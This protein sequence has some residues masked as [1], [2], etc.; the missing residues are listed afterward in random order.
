MDATNRIIE[1]YDRLVA[2]GRDGVALQSESDRIVFYVVS[3]RCEIDING[4]AS[5]FEQELNPR[6]LGMLID[7][8]NR[9]GEPGLAREFH[10]G[11]IL[12]KRDGFYEH[13]NWNKVSALTKDEIKAIGE[14]IGDRLWALDK[15]L[16][17]LLDDPGRVRSSSRDRL[18]FH[19]QHCGKIAHDRRPAVAAVRLTPADPFVAASDS[20]KRLPR[21][22]WGARCTANCIAGIHAARTGRD[23]DSARAKCAE[24]GG[25]RSDS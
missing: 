13:M 7:G 24:T 17:A 2:L 23:A 18:H 16:V 12:L 14:R 21:T 15:K 9:I 4:F 5:V 6:E 11:F 25:A 3:T 22:C 20:V 10:H 19:A 8:L 1:E